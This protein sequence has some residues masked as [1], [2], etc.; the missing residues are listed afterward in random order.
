MLAVPHPREWGLRR[1]ENFGFALLQPA[2]SVC[3]SLCAFFIYALSQGVT[4]PV[5]LLHLESPEKIKYGIWVLLS[6]NLV[7]LNAV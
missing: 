3:I 7:N 4:S 1:G 5:A 2:R 6:F